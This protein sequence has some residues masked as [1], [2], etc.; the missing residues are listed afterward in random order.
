MISNFG[1][2]NGADVNVISLKAGG[3]SANIL[4]WGGV[5][6]D[7][8]LNGHDAPLVLGFNK[9]ED[10]LA[11]SPYFG[12]C[13]GRFANRIN[14]GQFEINGQVFQVDKNEASGHHLHG[15]RAGISQQVWN[16]ENF[17]ETSVLLSVIDDGAITGFPGNCKITCQYSLKADGVFDVVYTCQSDQATPAN[18]AH[19]SYFNLDGS[20]DIFDHEIMIKADAYLPV[21]DVLIPT[22]E[23]KDV[24]GTDFDFRKMRSIRATNGFVEYDHNFCLSGKSTDCRHVATLRS[25]KSGIEMNVNSTEPGIQFYTGFG[26]LPTAN[27]LLQ[28]PYQRGAGLCL[29]TQIWPDAPN[30]PTFPNAILQPKQ[31]L[32]QHTEYV[33]NKK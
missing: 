17:D 10:Y 24:G 27:G 18:I 12:A 13:V 19:H 14:H 6:Q 5:L 31:Q 23:I 33:F 28:T 21:S 9:L 30:H 20:G 2:H 32:V 25:Q 16:I 29:E 7:L 15:G 8:R 3:L 22:G 11:H 1:C 26:V 4:N